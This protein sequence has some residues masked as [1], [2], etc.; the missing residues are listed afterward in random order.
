MIHIF[1]YEKVIIHNF[2]DNI[3]AYKKVIKKIKAWRDWSQP[4]PTPNTTALL[5]F[6]CNSHPFPQLITE[7]S[8][9]QHC[10]NRNACDKSQRKEVL[11]SSQT[12]L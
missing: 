3:F 6:Y 5:T 1:L 2:L 4:P 7:H 8:G 9:I 12:I 11:V 10:R